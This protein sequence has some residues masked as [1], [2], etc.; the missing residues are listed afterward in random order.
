MSNPFKLNKKDLLNKIPN[1]RR[2]SFEL[3]VHKA[4]LSFFHIVALAFIL[5]SDFIREI[6]ISRAH[7]SNIC[8]HFDRYLG[9][10]LMCSSFYGFDHHPLL[11]DLPPEV[12]KDKLLN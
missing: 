6:K 9:G 10:I 5:M 1:E 12:Q 2:S 11:G 7:L 4:L 8:F 3:F